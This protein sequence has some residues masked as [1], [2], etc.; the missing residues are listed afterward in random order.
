MRHLLLPA[1]CRSRF[2][3]DSWS[4]PVA[5]GIGARI[6]ALSGHLHARW[7][8]VRSYLI[9]LRTAW[10]S[11]ASVAV[12]FWFFL[13]WLEVQDLFLEVGH[14]LEEPVYWAI[15]YLLVI[16]AWALPVF[17]SARWILTKLEQQPEGGVN[18]EPGPLRVRIVV[19]AV[20]VVGC[21][22]AVLTGQLMASIKA[23]VV[24]GRQ[25]PRVVADTVAELRD[26]KAAT[27]LATRLQLVGISMSSKIADR[28]DGKA[29][30]TD[31]K[32]AIDHTSRTNAVYLILGVSTLIGLWLYVARS[33]LLLLVSLV[34]TVVVMSSLLG[35]AILG[36]SLYLDLLLDL[37]SGPSPRVSV[38]IIELL[39]A[40]IGGA[41]L[42]LVPPPLI[43]ISLAALLVWQR[44][45]SALWWL[46]TVSA[47]VGAALLGLI[48]Y[49]I[50]R[51][52]N[53]L[54][55][56]VGLA[57]LLIL[58]F[59]TT[60]A[61]A[62]SWWGLSP[63]SD[64]RATR[65]GQALLWLA[66][67]SGPLSDKMATARLVNPIFY[68]LLVV[69]IGVITTALVFNPV[70]VTTP[71]LHR[72]LLLPIILGMPVA[73]VTYLTYWSARS[74]YPL[75]LL[76]IVGLGALSVVRAAFPGDA[77]AVRIETLDKALARPSLDEALRQWAAANGCIL[78]K[79]LENRVGALDERECSKIAPIVVVAAGGGSRAAFHAAGIIGEIMDDGKFAPLRGHNGPV[80]S[81][82]FSSDGKFIVT[83]SEDRTARIWDANTGAE[84]ARLPG[85]RGRVN[86]AQFSPDGKRVVTGAW[87]VTGARRR[88]ALVRIWDV[89]DHGQVKVVKSLRG[90][91]GYVNSTA[92][93][94]DGKLVVTASDDGTARIW[95]ADTE[96][97]LARLEGHTG[98]VYSAAFDRERKR[99]VTAGLDGTARIWDV[100][101]LGQVKEFKFKSLAG[102]TGLVSSA[103]FS[104]D[105][106]LV[107]TGSADK[108]ARI[109][110][111]K[112]GEELAPLEGHTRL[113]YSAAFDPG[114]KRV[115]TAAWD[116][117]AR[118]WDVKN[119]RDPKLITRITGHLDDVNG[120]A[121]SP[122]GKLIVTS[123]HD[124]TARVWDASSAERHRWAD[125]EDTRPFHQ[126]LFAISAVSGGS[127]AAVVM[128]AALADSQHQLSTLDD[129]QKPARGILKPPCKEAGIS[130]RDWVG[131][132]VRGLPGFETVDPTNSWKDC[133]QLLV[134]GDFLS[135]VAVRLF[136]N[137]WLPFHVKGDR[138]QVLEEAWEKRYARLTE[139]RIGKDGQAISTLEEPMAVVR[140]RTVDKL[141]GWLPVLL[142]N[143]TAVDDGRRLVTSDIET[144]QRDGRYKVTG[145]VMRDAH[146]LHYLLSEKSPKGHKG[147]V[148]SAAFSH[149]DKLIVTASD[150]GTARIWEAN[151]GAEL[152]SLAPAKVEGH[153]LR[154]NSAQFS[155]DRKRV[156]TGA[157][158]KSKQV[159][160][161]DVSDLQNVK[162]VMPPL[163][164]HTGDVNS[165]AFSPDV[166][167]IVTAS[168]DKT[169]RIW[170]ATTGKELGRLEGHSAQVYSAAFDRDGQRVVTAAFDKTAR[171]W[172][173]SNPR[174]PTLIKQLAG[175]AG[176][177][178]SAAFSHDGKLVVTASADTTARIWDADTGK[179][180]GRL[181]GHS[182]QVYSAAFD[183]DSQRV[184][185]ASWDKTA[186]IWDVSN[187]RQP[188]QIKPLTG[189]TDDVNSAAFSHDGKLVV[190]ASDDKTARIW[191]AESGDPK[192]VLEQYEA[193][194]PCTRCDIRLSTAV[195]MSARFP[196]ISPTGVIPGSDKAIARVVDGGYHENFGAITAIEFAREVEKVYELSVAV[197]LINNEPKIPK[198]ECITGEQKG[199]V[200]PPPPDTSWTS[201]FPTLLTP[202]RAFD[203][204]RT[205]RGSHAAVN[206][207]EE[208]RRRTEELR[209]EELRKKAEELRSKNMDDKNMD[210]VQ[211]SSEHHR[212]SFI[213]VKDRRKDLPVSWW[214]S[215]HVQRYLDRQLL[216]PDNAEELV[217]IRS[218][219]RIIEKRSQ[220]AGSPGGPLQ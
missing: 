97:E 21:F 213:T 44:R 84:Q 153:K 65:I 199:P 186:R 75:V 60:A 112:S 143:G 49:G 109:W 135:P 108:T 9:G 101:N 203:N 156:V 174:Q 94:H 93:S 168:D 68:A 53:E 195:T 151:S 130:D 77:Y 78:R 11:A 66:R 217:K 48:L 166:K 59:L 212:F 172:D 105:G 191:D 198:M 54:T 158:E 202:Y 83:A 176:N 140:D 99:V 32:Y 177:V 15:F 149:D 110:D 209:K 14:P 10:V 131:S 169:A 20:L 119:P 120:A 123:S 87:E 189:H 41:V 179:E 73:V 193:R 114:G 92:F 210:D 128:Y 197:I 26:C 86:S 180:L 200:D 118:I 95:D 159:R 85:H 216:E 103:A 2:G 175:H 98:I 165:A 67:I 29:D 8:Y 154:L 139:K 45:R 116:K 219:L 62:V 113:V 121:F 205:A 36:T 137:D 134:A 178:N 190:T 194:V 204:T 82:A 138:A 4:G 192:G 1:V 145:D 88:F 31:G 129:R 12:A 55:S 34:V 96:K 74:R 22:A 107:V 144:V 61:A 162:E 115:I 147:W 3:D 136:S 183:R 218:L 201:W 102:H 124:K 171:I 70:S 146:S 51:V 52:E 58:P 126:Q 19:P 117:T 30:R 37:L 185:T 69:S 184:V 39:A 122:D 127:L 100:S 43:V 207:C 104:P 148:F 182:A 90:H 25:L 80:Y 81:A 76:V 152:A 18:G 196:G 188:K 50:I 150:D 79:R 89:S 215:R 7:L 13:S 187:P 214:L 208:L 170:D 33:S 125:R 71:Y 160:I 63:Q 47:I 24:E 181:E 141:K 72:A 161:W 155:P 17:V 164:G 46:G 23:P 42:Y 111:A 167:L 163:Q 6:K 35:A 64:G 211:P 27:C 16:L 220:Q 57:H 206:L 106:D 173:V 5:A 91:E 157:W 28:T 133:L 142:L 132:G 56:P 38:S 40:G